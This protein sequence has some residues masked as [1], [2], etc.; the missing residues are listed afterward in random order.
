M[1]YHC[2]CEA[3]RSDKIQAFCPNHLKQLDLSTEGE[4]MPPTDHDLA[5]AREIDAQLSP[6]QEHQKRDVAII[7]AA[8][9]AERERV[10]EKAARVG[11]EAAM[12]DPRN[13]AAAIRALKTK[14]PAE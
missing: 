12:F 10:L 1:K 7:A 8:L 4:T 11:A 6:F 9:A 2:G 3:V 14:S 13:V 5:T